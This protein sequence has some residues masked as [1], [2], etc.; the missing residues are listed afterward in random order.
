LRWIIDSGA[1]AITS[2]WGMIGAWC[3]LRFM[4]D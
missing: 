1:T 4:A 2:M 3:I